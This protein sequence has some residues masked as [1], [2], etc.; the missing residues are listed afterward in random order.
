MMLESSYRTRSSSSTL[1]TRYHQIRR[2]FRLSKDHSLIYL[3]SLFRSPPNQR[4][5]ISSARS[6]CPTSSR[7]HLL[8]S[9]SYRVLRQVLSV[10]RLREIFLEGGGDDLGGEALVSHNRLMKEREERSALARGW[11]LGWDERLGLG[12]TGTNERL[13]NLFPTGRSRGENYPASIDQANR[14]ESERR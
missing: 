5:R 11:A 8:P 6:A 10:V 14:V 12:G 1:L 3:H 13:E 9:G 2:I 4:D 7:T